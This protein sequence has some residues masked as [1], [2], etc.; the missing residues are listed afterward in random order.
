MI[1]G[2]QEMCSKKYL[3]V[4]GGF[5]LSGCSTTELRCGTDGNESYVELIKVQDTIR[6]TAELAKLCQFS[7]SENDA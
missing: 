3:L 4:F 2:S 7:R 6:S 1:D 5:V